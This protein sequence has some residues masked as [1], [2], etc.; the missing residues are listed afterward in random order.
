MR[1]V[2]GERKRGEGVLLAAQPQKPPGDSVSPL[3]FRDFVFDGDNDSC[4]GTGKRLRNT[5]SRMCAHIWV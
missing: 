3:S 5:R 2:W 4:S 1:L